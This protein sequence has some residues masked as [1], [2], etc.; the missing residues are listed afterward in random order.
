[1]AVTTGK[2]KAYN[3]LHADKETAK[4]NNKDA[5]SSDD[6]N[7]DD[8]DSE[9]GGVSDD[10]KDSSSEYKGGKHNKSKIVQAA[11]VGS[12]HGHGGH[13]DGHGASVRGPTIVPEWLGV[14]I[15]YVFKLKAR[16]VTVESEFFAGVVQ[17]I[18]CLYVLPVVPQQMAQA[19]FNPIPT[20]ICTAIT[21]CIGS[22]ISSFFTDMPFIIAPPTSVSI[23]YAVTMVQSNMSVDQG[24]N[25]I[26]FSGIALAIVGAVPP[27]SRFITRLIPDCIQAS[28]A[29]GIG[30]ITALA[31]A[32]EVSLVI[33]GKHTILDM[34]PLTDEIVVAMAALIIVAAMLHY[35]VKGAFAFGLIF[36][37]LTWWIISGEWPDGVVAS[38]VTENSGNIKD[39]SNMLT[40]FNLLFLYILTLNGLARSLSD[41]GGLTKKSGTIPRAGWLFIVCGLTT[42]LSGYFSGPPILISPES[43][44]GIKAGARTGFS[45]LVCGVLFGIA[46]FFYPIFAAVPPAGTAPLLIAVGV[47]LFN[48]VK[49]IDWQD[50]RLAFPS[51]IILFFIPFTYSILRG[52]AFGYIMY[53]FIGLFTGDM[54]ENSIQLVKSYTYPEPKAPKIV[55]QSDESAA[56]HDGHFIG[57]FLSIYDMDSPTDITIT[58]L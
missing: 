41:L 57:K 47:V 45:T 32:T 23:F 6:D 43:A 22:V 1:M 8:E 7:D 25:A 28:T 10:Y 51:Y 20:I 38:P 19:G 35:H 5:D 24:N 48:N 52:V 36:G 55:T 31:G 15:E 39:G 56:D 58:G 3:P 53:I 50:Y 12:A 44:A 46:T 30:M 27:L 9:E 42:V 14:Y 18:S 4:S 2:S 54:I 40:V 16:N 21:C 37:T 13:D 33:R 11:A 17:F 34:G 26:I 29:V 49:R